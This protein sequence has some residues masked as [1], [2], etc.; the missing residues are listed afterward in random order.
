MAPVQAEVI[1]DGRVGAATNITKVGNDF[2]IPDMLGTK[3]GANLFHSFTELNL[4]S[5]ESATFSGPA[6]VANVLARVTG[7]NPSNIDGTLRST[8]SGANLFLL[9]PKGIVFGANAALEVSGAFTASTADY[10]KLADGGRFDATNPANDVLTSAPVS[11]FGFLGP[12]EAITVNGS[13]LTNDGGIS[14]IGGNVTTTPG[15]LITAAG[16]PVTVASA[17]SQGELNPDGTPMPTAKVKTYGN[18]LLNRTTINTTGNASGAVTIRGGRLT[19][20]RANVLADTTG[21]A[22]GGKLT[23]KAKNSVAIKGGS[24]VRTGTTGPGKAGAVDVGAKSI[25]IE[26]SSLLGSRAFPSAP[27]EASAGNVKV[28]AGSLRITDESTISASTNGRARGGNVDVSATKIDI[29]GTDSDTPT[30]ILS[31]TNSATDGGRGGNVR[32]NAAMMSLTHGG[33]IRTD[34]GGQGI[35]GN[36]TVTANDIYIA[37]QGVSAKTGIFADALGGGAGAGKGGTV[38]VA[39][40]RLRIVDGGLISTKTTGPGAA[41]DTRVKAGELIIARQSSDFFTGIAVDSPLPGA[42]PGGDIIV[43][44]GRLTITTGG[45]I[46][47]N[48]RST[49]PGGS[50]IV[51]AKEITLSG[52]QVGRP[53]AFSNISADSQLPGTSGNGGDVSVIA[54]VLRIFDGARISANTFGSGS[55]G[56]VE[57]IARDGLFSQAGS[58][59]FTGVSATSQS[60]DQPGP[61]GNVRVAIRNLRLDGGGV[62]ANTVGPGRGGDVLIESDILNILRGGRIAADTEGLGIGGSIA[63]FANQLFISGAGSDR[64]T[65]IASRSVATG[66]GGNGGTIEVTADE[67]ELGGGALVAASSTSSGDGGSVVFRAGR[68]AMESGAS[69]EASASG[70]GIAGSVR[71]EVSEPLVMRGGSNISTTSEISDSGTVEVVSASDIVLEDSS[72]TVRATKGNAGRIALF[73][74]GTISLNNSTVL[75]EAGLTGGDVFIDPQFVLLT[76]SRISANAILGAGGNIDI[77]TNVFL[78]TESAVTASS[79]ASVQGTVRIETLQGDISGA[80]VTLGGTLVSTKTNLA[81]RCAMR[82]EG[83]VSTF[84][85]VGRGGVAP[86][87]DEALPLLPLPK[88]D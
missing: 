62:I 17:A 64:D 77:I 78:A 32:V 81:E 11:A 30:G 87:P 12:T 61:G 28:R 74:P 25:S 35:G 55:G 86:A 4:A 1:T 59:L 29:I 65:G 79:E 75:A 58:D 3:M 38:D 37:A 46:S 85:L 43:D 68:L 8:I 67:A 45:Q 5:G 70:A 42:G 23:I 69:I 54:D 10:L 66:F 19:F 39:A 73:A 14:L 13:Q 83:D 21:A 71:V 49:S 88:A 7:G 9:N 48:T 63:V 80:L 41:G 16:G 56:N 20:D 24:L 60:P 2:A 50:V 15:T 72:V 36:V 82:L 51:R 31:N 44:A 18:V 6:D 26:Q 22:T 57:V 47:A 53:D 33:Q 76:D 52:T 40:G 34:T 84:L 27:A